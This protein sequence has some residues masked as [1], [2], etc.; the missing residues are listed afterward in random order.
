MNESILKFAWKHRFYNQTQLTTTD[1]RELVVLKPGK[2]NFDAGPDFFL[3]DV[4]I[5]G[6]RWVGNVEIHIK[7]SDWLRH[8]HDTN[9]AY[10]NVT[11]HVVY[12]HDRDIQVNG[13]NLPTL[14]LK[15]IITPEFLATYD[16]IVAGK[17]KT[18]PCESVLSSVEPI[19]INSWVSRLLIERLSDRLNQL[20]LLFKHNRNDLNETFYQWLSMGFGAKVNK[21]A[22]LQLAQ[23]VP[24][25]LLRKYL[26][27]K[28]LA[29]ALLF[30]Q[31][32]MLPAQSDSRYVSHLIREYAHL[33]AK[34]RLRSMGLD[35]WKFM[36][37]RPA[38]F[39]TIRLAQ[40]SGLLFSSPLEHWYTQK[41]DDAHTFS[42]NIDPFWE[43]HYS[44]YE[45]TV[46]QQKRIGEDF[47]HHL[48][49]NVIA[50][51]RAFYLQQH[52]EDWVTEVENFFNSMPP[53][54][55]KVLR[56]LEGIGLENRCGAQSQG[57]LQLYNVY[58]EQKKCLL[59][60]IGYQILGK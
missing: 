29:D 2:E 8:G 13:V 3:A 34:H 14:E 39:P 33:K 24:Y 60:S 32:G 15:N 12:E 49:I 37:M 30:G 5:D 4:R 50:S 42:I 23:L 55:N 40:L 41:L 26:S 52:G 36:R 46:E 6:T 17:F 27:D 7:S 31:S 56:S 51:F 48:L 1:N 20:S 18:I 11:L 19:Y 43:R 54:R 44:F 22:F 53:E 45:S 59:C 25:S 28:R 38:N 16:Q 58:C 10:N 21:E 57:L 9:T 35:A 47:S